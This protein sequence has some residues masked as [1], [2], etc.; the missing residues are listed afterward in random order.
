MYRLEDLTRFEYVTPEGRDQGI[1]VR[2][3]CEPI[4]LP[5]HGVTKNSWGD[6]GSVSAVRTYC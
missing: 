2:H 4:C 6:A 1:N 3:R 5:A